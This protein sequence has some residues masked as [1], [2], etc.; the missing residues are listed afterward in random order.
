MR[1]HSVFSGEDYRP[2]PAAP[3]PAALR[4]RLVESWAKIALLAG[5]RGIIAGQ[6]NKPVAAIRSNEREVMDYIPCCERS[7]P[8]KIN[9]ATFYATYLRWLQHLSERL[10]FEHT[11]TIWEK[12]FAEYDEKLLL[13]V[14]SSGWRTDES[15]A[16]HQV[17]AK[18]NDWVAKMLLTTSLNLSDFEARN[19]IDK[20]PP[21]SQISD[22]FADKTVVKEISAY[23]AL[24]LRFDGLA[25]L[26]A[27]LIDKF[28]KQGELIVYDL[29]V[30]E[31]VEIGQGETG[32]VEQFIANFT[33]ESEIPNLFTAGLETK[34]ISK[35]KSEV[36]LD[37]L[38]C[39]WARYFQ[40]RHPTI[41]YLMACSTDEVAYKSFNRRLR[42]QRTQTIMEGGKK[43]DFKIFATDMK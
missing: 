10:G 12:T 14:L 20:T 3:Y 6:V 35:T 9:R 34:L 32:S 25:Y 7:F 42:M 23:D 13:K 17:S 29:L 24:L 39:E 27:A 8:Y 21:I 41:G 28:R 31:R 22:H 2:T 16:D 26:A 33:A 1:R 5:F 36:I 15:D 30:A 38:E 11:L 37:V 43:C 18:I 40:E 19:I 4:S